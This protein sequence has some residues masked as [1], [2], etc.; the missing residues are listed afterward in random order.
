VSAVSH[1]EPSRY[2]TRRLKP[3]SWEDLPTAVEC[4]DDQLRAEGLTRALHVKRSVKAGVVRYRF[5]WSG[6]RQQ[7]VC[8]SIEV[9]PADGV[10]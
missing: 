4:I 10:H 7:R 5:V 2:R 3:L 1:R 9:G 8:L 6:S